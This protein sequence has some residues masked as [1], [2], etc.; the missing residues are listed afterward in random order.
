MTIR[1]GGS[2][3]T[4]PA[5]L[6]EE[7][8]GAVGAEKMEEH[9]LFCECGPCQEEAEARAVEYEARDREGDKARYRPLPAFGCPSL[10][11]GRCGGKQVRC[12]LPRWHAEDHAGYVKAF[13]PT[14][15]RYKLRVH[16]WPRDDEEDDLLHE[17]EEEQKDPVI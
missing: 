4:A 10:R 1:D 14:M 7:M 2:V 12:T 16:R 11:G 17:L 9:G 6:E 8:S 15:R 5:W 3:A 13:D